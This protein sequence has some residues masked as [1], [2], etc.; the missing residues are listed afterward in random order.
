MARPREHNELTAQSLLDAAER[1]MMVAGPEA[2]SVR[3][4]AE[5]ANTTVRA[6]YS[7][8]G[9]KE[10]L[11]T[12]LAN[13]AFRLLEEE[14]DQLART[15][16]PVQDL[17]EFAATVYRPFVLRHPS[18]YRIAFQRVVPDMQVTRETRD[19]RV[20]TAV[21]LQE[22]VQRLKDAGLLGTR[23]LLQVLI[24]F[25]AMCEGLANIELRGRT[26]G[27]I[28]EGIEE[29]VWRAA[30]GSLLRG[31]SSSRDQAVAPVPPTATR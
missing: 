23:P 18:L 27:L 6:V 30:V 4:V 10:G 28:P 14:I 19:A 24:E 11:V 17:I 15:D 7:L 9:T 3:T 2:I 16:D 20:R 31:F 22:R 1:I 21:R 8:F 25:S 29:S 26:F 13:K 5:E 12:A